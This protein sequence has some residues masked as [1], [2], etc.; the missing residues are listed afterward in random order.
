MAAPKL[1]RSPTAVSNTLRELERLV[2][3]VLMD[4]TVDG[5]VLNEAGRKLAEHGRLIMRSVQQARE[6]LAA[7]LKVHLEAFRGAA[8]G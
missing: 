7:F 1:G 4:R 8:V 6:E 5:V 3:A 2:G